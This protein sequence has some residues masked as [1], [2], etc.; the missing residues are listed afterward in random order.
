[1][2]GIRRPDYCYLDLPEFRHASE[3][4]CRRQAITDPEEGG[5]RIPTHLIQA[6]GVFELVRAGQIRVALIFPLCVQDP[7]TGEIR[8]VGPEGRYVVEIDDNLALSLSSA[9]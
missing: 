7:V 9:V 1:V 2:E 4:L 5:I 8:A 3:L 6:P